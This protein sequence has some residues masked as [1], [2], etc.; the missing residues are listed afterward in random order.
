[1]KIVDVKPTQHI[2]AGYPTY[3][4]RYEYACEPGKYYTME[5]LPSK[6]TE[7]KLNSAL[8]DLDYQMEGKE[9]PV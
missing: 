9:F 5:Y 1:M 8:Y 3:K 2:W 4:V 6:E 7:Q